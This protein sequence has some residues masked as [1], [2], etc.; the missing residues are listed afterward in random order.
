MWISCSQKRKCKQP[1]NMWK[2]LNHPCL[3]YQ[4]EQQVAV[5]LPMKLSAL[6]DKSGVC[7]RRVRSSVWKH[8][9]I[10][11]S[12]F[13]IKEALLVKT[14]P[15]LAD[16]PESLTVGFWHLFL[17]FQPLIFGDIFSQLSCNLGDTCWVPHFLSFVKRIELGSPCL[18]QTC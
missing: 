12:S 7:K 11:V 16:Q 4:L 17:Q 6:D 1:T 9:L 8:V 10:L 18:G 14:L 5:H 13:S 15:E 3:K 2:M